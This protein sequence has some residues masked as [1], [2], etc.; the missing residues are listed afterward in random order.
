MPKKTE[1]DDDAM[2]YQQRKVLTE[3]E[4]LQGM[5][6]KQK[7]A[8]LWDY[9]KIHALAVII[10]IAVISSIIYNI[11]TPNVETK[12]YT[13]VIN[14]PFQD[15]NIKS[16]EKDLSKYLHLKPKTENVIFNTTF[17]FNSSK[18]YSLNMKTVLTTYIAAQDVDVIIAPESEFKSYAYHG[19]FDKLS[20]QLPT[21]LY[22]SLTD[23]FY[24]TNKEN[25]SEKSVFGVYL[26]NSRL[27]KNIKV[28]EPYVL[29]IVA[30]SRHSDNSTELI[31]YLF[32][33]QNLK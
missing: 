19:C 13:A 21:D 29:G 2:I 27:F 8:Y 7:L 9:Y 18:D 31:R 5:N 28:K 25:D 4:K 24:M 26:N 20:D 33:S 22:T 16:L 11:V 1:L 3:K 10:V 12:L 32:K 6:F 30:N 15:Q 17:Y 14:N 23:Q